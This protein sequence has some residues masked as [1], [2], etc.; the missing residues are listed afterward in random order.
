MIMLT[1]YLWN[2][3]HCSRF[4]ADD[5]LGLE[6]AEGS[7]VAID[8]NATSSDAIICSHRPDRKRRELEAA[9]SLFLISLYAEKKLR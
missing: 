6:D 9:K 5:D 4:F 7:K 1:C 2:L 8:L 3:I